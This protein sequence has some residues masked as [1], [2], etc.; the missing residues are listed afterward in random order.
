MDVPDTTRALT[1]DLRRRGVT[2]AEPWHT[3]GGCW[4]VL[5]P[6]GGDAHL[7][8]T[9]LDGP[10]LA[11]HYAD[12][13]AEEPG[14]WLPQLGLDGEVYEVAEAAA[15]VARYVTRYEAAS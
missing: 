13:E 5:V 15:L 14:T 7:L 12:H 4:A 8:V 11:G 9:D 2:R 3:G 10:W 6:M 1:A